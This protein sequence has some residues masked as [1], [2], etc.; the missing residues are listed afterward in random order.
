[1]LNCDMDKT[2]VGQHNIIVGDCLEHLPGITPQ[3]VDVVVTSPPYNL[4][5]SYRSY[6]DQ[7]PRDSYLR[8]LYD[9][10]ILIRRS[11]KPS[12]SFFLNVGSTNQEPWVMYDVAHTLRSIFVLQNHIIWVKSISVGDDSIGHFKPI[13]SPR[14]LN[15]NHESIFHFTQSGDVPID[16]LAVGVPFKDKVNI[17][18]RGHKQDKRCAGNVWLIP[19]ETVKSKDQKFGHP[20]GF[21]VEL[22]ER[23]LKLHGVTNATVLDPFMGVG[24][25]LIAA[26]RLGHCGIG[27]EIDPHY[28][29]MAIARL[30][31]DTARLETSRWITY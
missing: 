23:C 4:G 12:G 24:S 11:L 7:K 9:V 16:R 2:I 29:E 22:A 31:K 15:Q 28:A 21:P 10:G 14:Y 6:D 27:I 8:W 19:Y 13:S 26:E 17:A 3:S 25:T 20:A 5:V 30:Q 1:M 18:R